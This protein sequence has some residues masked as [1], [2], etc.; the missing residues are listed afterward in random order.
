MARLL[1]DIRRAIGEAGETEYR[2]A[3]RS[4]VSQSQISRL[5]RGEQ[6]MSVA[7]VERIA[8]A[9]GLDI[10]LKPQRGRKAK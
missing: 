5:M 8:G 2:I 7:N 1:D 3:Q 6:G 10:L 4:G 9:L